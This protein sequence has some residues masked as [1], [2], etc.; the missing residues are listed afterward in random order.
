MKRQRGQQGD[1]RA[2]SHTVPSSC[3]VSSRAAETTHANGVARSTTR[4]IMQVTAAQRAKS[5]TWPPGSGL[6][7]AKF[8]SRDRVRQRAAAMVAS[9]EPRG[10]AGLEG[11]P[12]VAF[13]GRVAG[14]GLRLN[15]TTSGNRGRLASHDCRISEAHARCCRHSGLLPAQRRRRDF[16]Q[17]W[18]HALLTRPDPQSEPNSAWRPSRE[19]VACGCAQ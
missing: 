13:F 19:I 9:F 1:Y 12:G 18:V 4:A 6:R 11:S 7:R 17:V 16:D 10:H 3:A 14:A 5:L 15:A 2:R 8:D